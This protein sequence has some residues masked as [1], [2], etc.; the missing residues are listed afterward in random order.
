MISPTDTEAPYFASS[1]AEPTANTT[2]RTSFWE[3]AGSYSR[4][5]IDG[6]EEDLFRQ[7]WLRDHLGFIAT[8]L[9]C[10]MVAI[11]WPYYCK[12]QIT[13][14]SRLEQQITDIRYRSLMTTAAL[15]EHERVGNILQR[16][17]SYQL[18]LLPATTPPYLLVDSGQYPTPVPPAK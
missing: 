5:L 14:V 10:L 15:I 16:I 7:P 9:G 11:V 12:Q 18:Q 6:A 8:C 2:P 3:R 17:E 1:D 13:E 4:G